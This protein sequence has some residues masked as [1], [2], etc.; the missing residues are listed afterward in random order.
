MD[1]AIKVAIE[2]Y[3]LDLPAEENRSGLTCPWCCSKD[4]SFSV[5]RTSGGV[6]YNCYRASC[7]ADN[8]SNGFLGT[9]GAYNPPATRV[10]AKPGKPFLG[11]IRPLYEAEQ[12]LLHS[13]YGI[14]TYNQD[15]LGV[16]METGRYILPVKGHWG[17]ERGVMARTP[18][19]DT[20]KPKTIAYVN[21]P[22]KPFQAW[23]TG[24][25]W[26]EQERDH[27][28]LVEDQWS[29]MK[30]V[31]ERPDY[32]A[33]ALLGTHMSHEKAYEIAGEKPDKITIALDKD[34]TRAAFDMRAQ[35]ALH[36]G[37]LVDVLPLERDI[38]DM[39]CTSVRC[40]V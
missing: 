18:P 5:K 11:D 40:L 1:R 28:V 17:Q 30:L 20:R 35:W 6:L 37:C 7:K 8:M 25:Y 26:G 39:H 38:K 2:A 9:A 21:D 3:A 36:W 29:A 32:R 31:Q 13:A 23:Y 27:I 10:A 12:A 33:I 24:T 4:A 22:A 16:D 14:C 15:V 34:A 19:G